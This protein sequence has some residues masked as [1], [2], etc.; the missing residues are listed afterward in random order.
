MH[1]GAADRIILRDYA[2]DAELAALYARA[3]AFVFLSDYEGFG[4]TPLEALTAGVPIVVLDQPVSREIYGAAAIF[5]ERP[6]P[7]LIAAALERAVFDDA[8]RARIM[9]AA[10]AVLQR[11]SWQECGHRTL[12]A[13]LAAG[14]R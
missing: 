13:L 6:E 1:S 2:P 3:R 4:M 5:V 11:Y 14:R 7:A 8:E 12:Q 9:S 10:A